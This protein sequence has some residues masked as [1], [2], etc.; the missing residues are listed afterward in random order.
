MGDATDPIGDRGDL[1]VTRDVGVTRGPA[2]EISFD[3]AELRAFEG[4]TVAAALLASGLR[5][6]RTSAATGAPRG[7]T[8]R[9]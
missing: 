6:L 9:R 1:R 4:E 2:V 3:G 5:V 7:V 8:S